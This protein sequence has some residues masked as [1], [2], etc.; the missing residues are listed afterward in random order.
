MGGINDNP[1][2]THFLAWNHLAFHASVAGRTESKTASRNRDLQVSS[3]SKAPT[4][5]SPFFDV[6]GDRDS[7][8]VRE[9]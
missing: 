5:A 1:R 8:T 3:I 6:A 4:L 7:R 2:E 9:T